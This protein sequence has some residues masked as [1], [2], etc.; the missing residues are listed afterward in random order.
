M[1][2]AVF[3]RFATV[4]KSLDPLD[5]DCGGIRSVFRRFKTE[6]QAQ[7]AHSIL[8]SDHHHLELPAVLP[9][10]TNGHGKDACSPEIPEGESYVHCLVNH[11]PPRAGALL[12]K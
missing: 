12:C 9:G 4:R 2:K 7:L 3:D 10:R 11:F 5:Y 6:A 8:L 1:E